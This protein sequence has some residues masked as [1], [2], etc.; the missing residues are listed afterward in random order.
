LKENELDY[1]K[2]LAL[3]VVEEVSK[4]VIGRRNEVYLLLTS[5]ISGGHVLIEGVPGVAKTLLAKAFAYTLDLDY[6]RIQFTPDLLPSDI[7]GTYIF[8][9]RSKDFVFRKG[10]IF[11]NILLADEI[12]RASPKTQSALLEAMQEQQVTVEGHTFDLPRPFMVIATLNPIETEGVF[13]LPEAQ[14]DRFMMKIVLDY[15]SPKEELEILHRQILIHKWLINKVASRE[16]IFNLQRLFWDIHVSEAVE[17]YIIELVMFTRKHKYVKLG[18][19]PRATVHLY[20]ASK[21]YALLMGRDYVLPDDVKKLAIPILSH[22]IILTP[23]ALYN[24]VRG[25]EVVKDILNKITV[26][27]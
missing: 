13:P 8:D 11:T 14:L 26:P 19:S 1:A 16:D 24:G 2:N 3:N 23:D 17:R 10:P 21:A 22:R 20:L 18:A 4:I 9:Q 5:L 7:T 12:N 15:P 27:A 25:E 6:K